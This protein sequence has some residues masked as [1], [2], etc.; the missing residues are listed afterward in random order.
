MGNGSRAEAIGFH[1]NEKGTD[2]LD[3]VF[4]VSSCAGWNSTTFAIPD[5]LDNH[6]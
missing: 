6:A 1:N 4:F 2:L 3:D 5:C